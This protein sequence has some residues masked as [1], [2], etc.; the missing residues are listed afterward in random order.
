MAMPTPELFNP[1]VD[2]HH[3]FY[4]WAVVGTLL[5]TLR[6]HSTGELLRCIVDSH[7]TIF[8]IC[9][10]YAL[11]F[12]CFILLNC[13]M[14]FIVGCVSPA[15][16][17]CAICYRGHRGTRTGSI[18]WCVEEGVAESR[19]PSCFTGYVVSGDAHLPPTVR[20]DDSNIAGHLVPPRA[21][22]CRGSCWGY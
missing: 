12:I 5:K 17:H 6:T 19:S 14:Y 18:R 20:G 8:F 9:N 16:Y 7:V 11:R 21:S 10:V 1:F 2:L 22:H 4:L 3:R 15:Y 13:V